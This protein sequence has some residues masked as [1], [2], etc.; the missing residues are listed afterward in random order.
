MKVVGDCL[1]AGFFTPVLDL[2]LNFML[3]PDPS[4]A[5][6]LRSYPESFIE[7]E[8]VLFIW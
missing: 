8:S 5:F 1:V 6:L 2:R 3:N 7:H 4:V